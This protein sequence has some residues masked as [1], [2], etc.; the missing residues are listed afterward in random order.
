MEK[1]K[2]FFVSTV[3]SIS[4]L[5]ALYYLFF[6]FVT[7]LLIFSLF[8]VCFFPWMKG[9]REKAFNIFEPV[10]FF[11][12]VYFMHFGLRAVFLYLKQY[13]SN[14]F[15][16]EFVE[17]NVQALI[18]QFLDK[19]LLLC[20]LG[21]MAFL[22]GYYWKSYNKNEFNKQSGANH[23][24]DSGKVYILAVIT[25]VIG[26]SAKSVQ[27]Y[28]GYL[29]GWMAGEYQV[30]GSVQLFYYLENF[31]QF[32]WVLIVFL[33]YYNRDAKQKNPI[34]LFSML[35][36]IFF[37]TFLSGSKYFLIILMLFTIMV[38][39]CF[40]RKV[41]IK[42][43]AFVFSLI[44][45]IV[46][47]IS[48]A[49]RNVTQFGDIKLQSIESDIRHTTDKMRHNIKSESEKQSFLIAS[50]Q[51][52]TNRFSSFDGFMAI[53]YALSEGISDY[54]YGKGVLNIFKIIIPSAIYPEKYDYP[55]YQARVIRSLFGHDPEMAIGIA[56]STLGDLYWDFHILGILF[57]MFLTGAVMRKMYRRFFAEAK[58]P[59]DKLIYI[60]IYPLMLF[61][62]EGFLFT[63][64]GQIIRFLAILLLFRWWLN[65]GQRKLLNVE[66]ANIQARQ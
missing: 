14:E 62:V 8:L 9:F 7:P 36:V 57:G 35:G 33:F 28:Y 32:S 60:V 40:Y 55:N 64:Y 52:I 34:F 58:N 31:L 5:A 16:N 37:V 24:I 23:K 11:S 10:Y 65:Q 63:S 21:I 38:R 49:Y 47:P 4:T 30:E 42:N 19:T 15:V 39:H 48:N 26:I 18:P 61:V 50:L 2:S 1:N 56:V 13:A 20:L 41:K 6:S 53:N 22:V 45:I 17:T 59:F 66:P 54:Q 43:I 25:F 12:V 46:F 3:L 27:L 51:Q 44:L 29:G